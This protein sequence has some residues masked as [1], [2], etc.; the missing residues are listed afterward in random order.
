[1]N[2]KDRDDFLGR[3]EGELKRALDM[4]RRVDQDMSASPR[5]NISGGV[6]V[7]GFIFSENTTQLLTPA[8][9]LVTTGP[10]GELSAADEVWDPFLWSSQVNLESLDLDLD[11]VDWD[12]F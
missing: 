4:F 8:S 6:P 7:G 5:P 1:M 9:A 12:N 2:V 3:A 10:S 11:V